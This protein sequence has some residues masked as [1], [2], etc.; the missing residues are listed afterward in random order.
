MTR[1]AVSIEPTMSTA[2]RR[3]RT[4]VPCPADMPADLRADLVDILAAALVERY[5]R[6]HG[7]GQS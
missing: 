7:Q 1:T 5:R 4:A 6:E 2:P 3:V